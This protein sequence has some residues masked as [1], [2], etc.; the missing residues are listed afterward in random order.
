VVITYHFPPD[1]AVGGMRWFGLTKYLAR[2]GWRSWVV[3][4]AASLD[5]HGPDGVTVDSCLRRT[6]LNDLYRGWRSAG[7]SRRLPTALDPETLDDGA[8]EVRPRG[9][10]GLRFEI[11]LALSFPDDARG[12][13]WRAARRARRLIARWRPDAVV[14]SGP[15][16]SAHLVAWLATRGTR[17]RWIIDLR[18]PWAGPIAGPWLVSPFDHSPVARW[19]IGRLERLTLGSAATVVCNTRELAA[20]M[21]ARHPRVRIEYLPNGADPEQLPVRPAQLFAGPALVHLGTL[22]GQRDLSPV[23]EA[24]RRFLDRHP[25]AARAAPLL[26][27]AGAADPAHATRLDRQLEALGLGP[28]VETRG[29]VPRE[30]AL[31]LAARSKLAIVLAQ[32]QV[33]QAPAKL[34]E[35]V[36]IGLPTVVLAP[37]GGAAAGEAGRI[38]AMAIDPGDVE[39]LVALIERAAGGFNGPPPPPAEP[40]DYAHLA[41]RTSRVLLGES[42]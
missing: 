21:R 8:V 38:G 34:Y 26:R 23:L 15:P 5:G 4:G 18:D 19:L 20:A 32:G 7:A 14:S 40:F 27:L 3:T 12:W 33:L 30:E 39:A 17:T 35:M 16:H 1:P 6:T 10:A 31:A 41:G 11:G 9:I 37:P 24:L 22:Y 28:F 36:A 29:V 42:C 2:L 13:L 25:E